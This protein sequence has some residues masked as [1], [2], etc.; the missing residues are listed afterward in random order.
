[1]APPA[2][3]TPSVVTQTLPGES[4]PLNVVETPTSPSS[5][6][7]L[8]RFEFETGRGNEGTKVLM[9]EWDSSAAGAQDAGDWDV[10]WEGKTQV[11]TVRDHEKGANNPTRRVYFLLPPG[12]HIPTLIDISQRSGIRMLRT[13]PMPAIFPAGLGAGT[14]EAGKRGVLHTLWAKKR[15]AELEAEIASEM[16]TNAES[17]GLEMAVQECLWITDHFGI[18]DS[19]ASSSA[20]RGMPLSLQS[21]PTSPTSPT[22]PRAAMGGRLGEK[23]R[24]LRLATSP[25]ELAAATQGVHFG[26]IPQSHR[27]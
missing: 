21:P 2:K 26:P 11:L 7:A 22:S 9:V 12:A 15:L 1:M 23:L 6:F 25:V 18:G 20:R 24:G 16:Q 27:Y 13:K 19:T 4:E 17:I 14:R 5:A 10:S 8:S 3:P